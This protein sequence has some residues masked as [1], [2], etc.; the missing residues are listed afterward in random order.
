MNIS[1]LK[2]YIKHPTSIGAVAPS[3]KYLAENMMKPIDFNNCNCIVEYGAGTGIFTSELIKRRKKDTKLLIIEKNEKFYN[4]LMQK[5]GKLENVFIINGDAQ[6][7][8]SY[9]SYYN[10]PAVNYIVS[11]L[12]FASLPSEISNRILYVTRR[13]LAESKGKFITFQYTLFK[14]GLFERFFNIRD[15]STTIRNIP[16]AFV[17]TMT[18]KMKRKKH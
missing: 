10:I 3:S 17:L 15:I 4:M 9:L 14:K 13:I 6:K 11:G 1:F 5:F 12:P 2:E 8:K 18:P 7:L 16:P